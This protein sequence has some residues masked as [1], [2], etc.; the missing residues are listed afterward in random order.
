MAM[1]HE[2]GLRAFPEILRLGVDL[3]EIKVM[4]FAKRFSF[5]VPDA[6]R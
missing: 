5:V 3:Y 2:V 1:A 6:L 4:T